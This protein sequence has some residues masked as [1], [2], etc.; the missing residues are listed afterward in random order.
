MNETN[1]PKLKL[2]IQELCLSQSTKLNVFVSLIT[3]SCK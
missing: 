2:L 1:I 3:D